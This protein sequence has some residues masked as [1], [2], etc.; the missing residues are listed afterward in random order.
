M[1]TSIKT[2]KDLKVWEYSMNLAKKVY[3]AT[4]KFPNE[5]RF[6]I[7]DQI[8]RSAVSIPSNIAEGFGRGFSHDRIRFL[9]IARGSCCEL[10]TQI[11]LAYKLSY[12]KE[13]E[14]K[15]LL[16]ETLEITKM[17]NGLIQSTKNSLKNPLT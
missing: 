8:R 11:M 12:L 10:E 13:S 15:Q 16:D 9:F 14:Q 17:I 6:G 7:T 2:F 3:N 4:D 5:E 1:V